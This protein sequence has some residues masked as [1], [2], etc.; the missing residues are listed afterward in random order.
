[1]AVIET[2]AGGG[3]FNFLDSSWQPWRC[4]VLSLLL[5]RAWAIFQACSLA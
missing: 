4:V 5:M 3:Q 2:V 1:M